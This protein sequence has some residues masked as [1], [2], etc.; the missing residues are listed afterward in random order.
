MKLTRRQLRKLIIESIN[1]THSGKFKGTFRAHP[2]QFKGYDDES[3]DAYDAYRDYTL[4]GDESLKSGPEFQRQS[5]KRQQSVSPPPPAPPQVPS[6]LSTL[7]VIDYKEAQDDSDGRWG[8]PPGPLPA[9]YK[10]N[11]EK[12]FFFMTHLSSDTPYPSVYTKYRPSAE[13]AARYQAAGIQGVWYNSRYGIGS[14]P[15]DSIAG[16]IKHAKSVRKMR[17]IYS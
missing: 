9:A 7:P 1:E 12:P 11:G 16:M 6:D 17:D 14:F 4:T 13:A 2:S 10:A 5:R 3:D 8:D 15:V